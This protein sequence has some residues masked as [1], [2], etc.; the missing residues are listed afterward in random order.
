MRKTPQPGTAS[1]D[2]AW[3]ASFASASPALLSSPCP[4]PRP[5]PPPGVGGVGGVLLSFATSSPITMSPCTVTVEVRTGRL[6]VDGSLGIPQLVRDLVAEGDLADG[7]ADGLQCRRKRDDSDR[8]GIRSVDDGLQ[9]AA[10]RLTKVR[11]TNGTDRRDRLR[12]RLAIA[13]FEASAEARR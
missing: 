7:L 1:S 10:G 6:N 4:P 13:G 8:E 2:V 5:P 3:A 12:D 9:A 11:L